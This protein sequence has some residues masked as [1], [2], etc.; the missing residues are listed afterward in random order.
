MCDRKKE[1]CQVEVENRI[2]ELMVRLNLNKED[3]KIVNITLE[4]AEK[5]NKNVVAIE[6]ENGKIITGKERA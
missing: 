2:K 4:K 1:K 3:R 5:E 6:L